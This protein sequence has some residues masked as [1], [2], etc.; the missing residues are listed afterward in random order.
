MSVC[1]L[2]DVRVVVQTQQRML[3]VIE[4]TLMDAQL[5]PGGATDGRLSGGC[6]FDG[7]TG[8]DV[9]NGDC[10]DVSCHVTT[11]QTRVNFLTGSIYFKKYDVHQFIHFINTYTDSGNRCSI[12]ETQSKIITLL[13]I[14][15]K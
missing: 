4:D 15:R 10:V 2:P 1:L 8:T 9:T 3:R 14:S 12:E 11:V 7:E 5:G 13:T 6:V